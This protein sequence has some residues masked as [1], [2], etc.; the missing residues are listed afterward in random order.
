ME[1][2]LRVIVDVAPAVE[3]VVRAVTAARGEEREPEKTP[4][5]T[6]AVVAKAADPAPVAVEA[7]A[8]VETAAPVAGEQPGLQTQAPR[9]QT[10]APYQEKPED[11]LPLLRERFGIAA[12][13]EDRDE[14]QRRMAKEL[15]RCVVD[16]IRRV[17]GNTGAKSIAD[18]RDDADRERFIRESLSIT[19]QSNSRTFYC[20]PF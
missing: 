10:Q 20:E 3:R 7:P 4:A 2:T 13:K 1:M 9:L 17:T 16:I 18:L 8:P 12:T 6:P 19:Y 11:V 5:G 15:N 14:E